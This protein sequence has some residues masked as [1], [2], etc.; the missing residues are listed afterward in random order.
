MVNDRF[1]LNPH[2]DQH[3]DNFNILGGVSTTVDAEREKKLLGWSGQLQRDT[4]IVQEE[5]RS[6]L[7]YEHFLGSNQ[8]IE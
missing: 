8:T 4:N 7:I 1:G 5:Y 2:L 6:W 3:T